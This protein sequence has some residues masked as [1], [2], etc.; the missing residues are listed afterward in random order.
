VTAL[1][2]AQTSRT[3]LEWPEVLSQTSPKKVYMRLIVTTAIFCVVFS[4]LPLNKDRSFKEETLMKFKLNSHSFSEG[5]NIPKKCT[6]DGEDVFLELHWTDQPQAAKSFALIVDVPDAPAGTWV[7]WV[8]FDL[9]G[10]A[11]D[12]PEAA[13]RRAPLPAGAQ[14]GINDFKKEGYGGPCPPPGKPH[15]YFFSFTHSTRNFP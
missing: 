4:Y 7:H 10:D 15:R 12:L 13:G 2:S 8:L 9:P 3:E 1:H 6:C 5:G 14:Q 11:H